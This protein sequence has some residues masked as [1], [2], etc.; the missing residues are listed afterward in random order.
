MDNSK[1]PK[2]VLMCGGP[3]SGKST[4]AN[5]RFIVPAGRIEV[6]ANCDLF[7]AEFASDDPDVAHRKSCFQSESVLLRAIL[8]GRSF[9]M[10]GTGEKTNDYSRILAICN[11]LGFETTL[12]YVHCPREIAWSRISSRDRHI[13]RELFDRKHDG[14][15]TT[16]RLLRVAADQAVFFDNTKAQSK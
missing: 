14:A 8:D 9:L 13:T 1:R 6:V 11:N 15:A 16:W 2:A 12:F 4:I 3:G 10:E 5:D 7:K